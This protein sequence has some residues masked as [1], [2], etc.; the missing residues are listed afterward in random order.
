MLQVIIDIG[1]INN[2]EKDRGKES[3]GVKWVWDAFIG[4]VYLSRDPKNIKW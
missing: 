4:K 1:K 3:L 2:Q